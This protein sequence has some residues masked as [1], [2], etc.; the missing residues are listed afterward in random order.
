MLQD[1]DP[2]YDRNSR[3]FDLVCTRS[4]MASCARHSEEYVQRP[5]LDGN[6]TPRQVA[7]V[8]ENNIRAFGMRLH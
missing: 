4:H 5:E 7:N 1:P 3:I 6:T 8:A 2:Q